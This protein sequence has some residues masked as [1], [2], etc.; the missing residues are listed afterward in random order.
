MMGDDKSKGF[1]AKEITYFG[2]FA[3]LVNNITGAGIVDLP[4]LFQQAGWLTPTI[5]VIFMMVLG[6]LSSAMLCEAMASVPGNDRFQ[7]RVELTS[8]SKIL[9]NKFGYYAT[10]IVL[11][12]SLQ[13]M[14][15]SGIIIA[16]QT[17]D[18]MLLQI[19][20]W[21]G[22][23]EFYPHPGFSSVTSPPTGADSPFDGSIVL[24]LGFIIV[25]LLSV[26]L[27]IFNLDENMWVQNAAF[28]L[29]VCIF[30][31]WF[32]TFFAIGLDFERIPAVGS[33]QTQV[34]GQIIF[35]FAYV[36]TIPSWVNEKREN[37]SIN[38]SLWSSGIFSALIYISI[39]LFGGWALTISGDENLLDAL[40]GSTTGGLNTFAVVLSYAFPLIVLLPGIPVYSIIVRYNLIETELCGLKWANFWG[41]L[42]PWIVSIPF[43]TG[44]GF[45]NLLNW[46]S[47]FIN[48]IVNFIIPMLLFIVMRRMSKL[49][50][51]EY[52][53]SVQTH[54]ESARLPIEK[55][56]AAVESDT[57][58][59]GELTDRS[60][61]DSTSRDSNKLP[62]TR[63]HAFACLYTAWW[64]SSI[65]RVLN[66]APEYW[67]WFLTAL[68]TQLI[69]VAIVLNIVTAV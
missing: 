3:L 27:G 12:V 68:I 21:N 59:E 35:D 55:E 36:I 5:A 45:V 9:F 57:D 69:L 60:S 53:G 52:E 63:Y 42:F 8:L 38:Y 33:D 32:G 46:S 62:T 2:S 61:I 34:L 10:Q 25:M 20:S 48:G 17:M 51:Y 67:A 49:K 11:N 58:E 43:L 64:K 28:I 54:E 37:V 41:V 65:G 18:W 19:F 47:L 39:G 50:W 23:L 15:M 24:S 40:T 14:N 29:T 13:A 66:V 31:M 26:P 16:A 44:D 30:F 1:G 7:G 22:A 6:A 4:V 56:I